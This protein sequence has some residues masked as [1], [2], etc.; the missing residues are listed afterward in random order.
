MRI[1]CRV[2]VVCAK[3][4][5]QSASGNFWER[6]TLVVDVTSG[7]RDI[8]VA[9]VFSGERRTAWLKG[10]KPGDLV[11]VAFVP[12]SREYMGKWYTDLVGLGLKLFRYTDLV[13]LGVKGDTPENNIPTQQV[14]LPAGQP[15]VELPP[16]PPT[17]ADAADDPP[18]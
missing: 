4:E 13:G 6:Q 8:P 1:L 16:S 11:D 17:I 15:R 10:L 7:E 14:A 5:G 3:E 12:E 18:F 9:I 2:R